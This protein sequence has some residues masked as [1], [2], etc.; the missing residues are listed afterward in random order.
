MKLNGH[1]GSLSTDKMDDTATKLAEAWLARA[2]CSFCNLDRRLRVLSESECLCRRSE[3]GSRSV[4]GF[5]AGPDVGTAPCKVLHDQW[6]SRKIGSRPGSR[7]R[8]NSSCFAKIREH[9]DGC[10]ISADPSL[11][12][13]QRAVWAI[14]VPRSRRLAFAQVA[15]PAIRSHQGREGPGAMPGRR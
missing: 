14:H 2:R 11:L 3:S 5:T 7:E 6:R 8:C 9:R 1:A 13:R 10:T 15:G 12:W 4:R